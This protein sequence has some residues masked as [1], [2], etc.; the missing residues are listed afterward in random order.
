MTFV[1]VLHFSLDRDLNASITE[2]NLNFQ[3]QASL[4]HHF[5]ITK[6]GL[7]FEKCSGISPPGGRFNISSTEIDK[8][9]TQ[10][11]LEPSFRIQPFPEV[12]EEIGQVEKSYKI[13]ELAGS[14]SS[15]LGKSKAAQK[16]EKQTQLI[17][18]SKTKKMKKLELLEVP[19]VKTKSWGK[20]KKIPFEER[21][22][23]WIEAGYSICAGC[24]YFALEESSLRRHKCIPPKDERTIKEKAADIQ[25]KKALEES[26]F[27]ALGGQDLN[28]YTFKVTTFFRL[29]L[30]I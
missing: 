3:N 26:V 8:K 13:S 1:E 7:E 6:E 14:K 17:K 24:G 23:R 2:T 12:V 15:V 18:K 21:R 28:G 27:S 11:R 9:F 25:I 22:R 10:Q 4:V 5:Y 19:K 30:I 20:T 29:R 16:F